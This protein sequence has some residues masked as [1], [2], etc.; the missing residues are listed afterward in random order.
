MAD[1]EYFTIVEGGYSGDRKVGSDG[2]LVVL[3]GVWS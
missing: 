1:T 3:M 2:L